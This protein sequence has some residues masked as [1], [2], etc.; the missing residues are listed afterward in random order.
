M[1]EATV[2]MALSALYDLPGA[3]EQLRVNGPRPDPLR[4]HMLW[5][6]TVGLVGFGQIARAVAE[7]LAEW[8]VRIVTYVR[9]PRPLP[10]GVSAV[11]LD[12][13]LKESDVVIVLTALT[14]ETR[15]LLDDAKL[16]LM[17][18]NVVLVNMARGAIVD[19]EA[20][21]ALVR[22]RPDM[23]LA[24]DVFAREPLP[25]ESPLRELPHTVLTPHV[26]GHTVEAHDILPKLV[27]ESLEAVLK[28][29]APRYVCNPDI[30]DAWRERWGPA[31]VRRPGA[32]G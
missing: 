24:L 31:H 1:A 12:T 7:R 27:L 2:L 3:M 18:P 25:L 30:A 10:A 23:R 16:R 17:K 19:E 11:P 26:V 4:A 28:G 8:N 21:V 5:A 14:D 32:A 13:L 29:E 15:H 9:S 20:L 6:K 22:E